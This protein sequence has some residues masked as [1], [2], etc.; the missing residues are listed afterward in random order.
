VG[1]FGQV[2]VHLAEA[3]FNNPYFHPADT[4]A[5]LIQLELKFGPVF[6]PLITTAGFGAISHWFST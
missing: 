1:V 3:L 6:K 2:I 5:I 4:F